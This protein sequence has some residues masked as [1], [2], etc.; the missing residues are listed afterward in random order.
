MGNIKNI[1]LSRVYVDAQMKKAVCKVLDSGS[2]ILGRECEAFEKEFSAF[3]GTKYAALTGSGT[4]AI[5]LTLIAL[6]VRPGDEIIVPALTAFP[7]IEPILSVGAKPVFV[8][9]DDAYLI[10]VMKIEKVISDKTVGIIPVHLYGQP[11]NMNE[12]TRL[13]KKHKFFVLEDCCQA[14]GAKFHNRPVGGI[15]IAGC[16]SFYPS[17][18]LTVCG[19]GG[20]VTT[21]NK[22]IYKKICVLRDHGRTSKYAHSILGYNER[23]NEA[24]AAI[25]RIG[26]RNLSRFN[27]RRREIAGLYR[28]LLKGL[29]LALPKEEEWAYHVYHMFVVQIEEREKVMK[30]LQ[31]KGISTGIHY[32]IPAYLQAPVT[33]SRG[34]TKLPFTDKYCRKI[35]SLPIHPLLNDDEVRYIY[36]SLK[37]ILDNNEI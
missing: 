30:L 18:N 1:P 35:L 7:T 14:H 5:W 34:V 3:I 33:K 9:V 37:H 20:M 27:S 16:F 28:S 31:A 26:L 6:D 24:Q 4:A 21:N 2:Y 22:S 10:D 12:I 13:A 32:P 23:F 19:D 8:D 15:G 29:R 25:G 36:R 17:K 11:A